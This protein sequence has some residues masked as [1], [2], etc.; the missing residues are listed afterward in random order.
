MTG[1][2]PPLQERVPPT[3]PPGSGASGA[4]VHDSPAGGSGC[5]FAACLRELRDGGWDLPAEFRRPLATV[6]N[7]PRSVVLPLAHAISEFADFV[8][9]QSSVDAQSSADAWVLFLVFLRLVLH[10]VPK[11]LRDDAR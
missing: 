3:T 7:I 5:D 2:A 9:L 6:P 10:C 4:S 1:Q 11:D 8:N